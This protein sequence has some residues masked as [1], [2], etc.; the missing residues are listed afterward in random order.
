MNPTPCSRLTRRKFLT[1]TTAAMATVTILP[2]GLLKAAPND[3]P[4]IAAVGVGGKG[5]GDITE[6]SKDGAAHV[7]AFCDVDNAGTSRNGKKRAGSGFGAAAEKW[8]DAKRYTD[9]REM[10][11]KEGKRLN[12]V[13]ISTPDHMHAPVTMTALNMGIA[14]YTQKPLT[15]TIHEARQL[16]LAAKKAGVVT[17][18]GNQGHSGVPYRTLV[19]LIQNGAIGKVKEAHTWSN[20]PIWA[21]HGIDR[22][23]GSSPIP[24]GLNWDLWLGVAPERPF[25]EKVYH[26]FAWRGWYDFGAGA[27]G[28]MGCHIID[29]VYWSLELTAPTRVWYE[30]PTPKPETFPKSETITYEFP[31]TK[32][33]S[34]STVRVLWYDGGLLPPAEL[35]PLPKDVKLPDNGCLLIGEKG[36]LLCQHGG[37]PVLLPQ[38]K[39]TDY[40]IP[41]ME[42][43]DH[44]LQ[45]TNAIRGE[46]TTT[47]NFDYAGRLTETVLLGTV[48]SRFANERLGWD[49]ANLRF[50]NVP[51]ANDYV[52][53]PYRQGWAVS[54][55]S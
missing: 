52:R 47:S 50:T 18:M 7:V 49:S 6:T 21:T 33:T 43:V 8:P 30:G 3:K 45:W 41:K 46:G 34:G 44:Y 11:D 17:Q 14:T 15:R 36:T 27:L 19:Q 39:F 31:G 37:S 53:Q 54:G 20:R 55:L 42:P 24:E 22:P 48:A 4:N 38:E 13:T 23:E 35:A 28:D 32:Y 1:G 40:Q 16:T 5:W 10:L 29:P 12:G 51:K 26:P 25:V 2:S 9:W